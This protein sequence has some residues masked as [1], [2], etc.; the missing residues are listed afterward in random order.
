MPSCD[1]R[2]SDEKMLQVKSRHNESYEMKAPEVL[3]RGCGRL[4]C[5]TWQPLG[6]S[7]NRVPQKLRSF[8]DSEPPPRPRY[9]RLGL[10]RPP[11][12]A[13]AS[14]PLTHGASGCPL[15]LAF[16]HITQQAC[17]PPRLLPAQ[18]KDRP[19][20]EARGTASATEPAAFGP[21]RTHGP[22]C[23]ETGCGGH[24]EAE[25]DQNAPQTLNPVL[26]GPNQES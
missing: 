2:F 22:S 24:L 9:R 15:R 12:P 18:L 11:L 3:A 20:C 13:A 17:R 10:E 8:L 25:R 14:R 23:R 26:V 19:G 5:G 4:G 7:S 1:L 16:P 6:G 21:V